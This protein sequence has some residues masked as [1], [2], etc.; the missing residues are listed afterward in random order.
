MSI[1]EPK[2]R[3][4]SNSA[5]NIK[6]TEKVAATPKMNHLLNTNQIT[7]QKLTKL[8]LTNQENNFID[9]KLKDL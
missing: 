4:F 1:L 5:K 3:P 6:K 2:M 7:H 9:K 8:L